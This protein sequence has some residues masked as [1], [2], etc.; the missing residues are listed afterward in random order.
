MLSTK[1]KIKKISIIFFSVLSFILVFFCFFIFLFFNEEKLTFGGSSSIFPL[2]NKIQKYSE[3]LNKK[4]KYISSGSSAGINGVINGN[5]DIGFV[6]KEINNDELKKKLEEKKSK[7]KLEDFK[8]FKFVEDKIIFLVNLPDGC[9]SETKKINLSTKDIK[10]IYKFKRTWDSLDGI[11][12]ENKKKWIKPINRQEGSGTRLVF[13]KKFMNNEDYRDFKVLKSGSNIFKYILKN[14][15]SFGYISESKIEG[16]NLENEIFVLT[17][18][19]H[20]YDDSN[21]EFSRPF[22]GLYLK[23][24][25]KEVKEF[26]EFL[27]TNIKKTNFYFEWID[28]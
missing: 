15:N 27:K 6:S 14:N 22:V 25:K 17:I 11:D 16:E 28:Y 7:Y 13:E 1:F 20:N 23:T 26:L 10:D 9:S 5:F 3:K 18:N 24:K 21:Y 12:C 2:M 19:N 4:Y 8:K